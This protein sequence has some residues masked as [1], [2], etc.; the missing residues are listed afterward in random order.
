MLNKLCAL[1]CL[2]ASTG[3]VHAADAPPK[4]KQPF[5]QDQVTV[6]SRADLTI[7][8]SRSDSEIKQRELW[9]GKQANGQ[10]GDWQKHGLSF[11]RNDPIVWAPPE[12]HWRVHVRIED[13]SGL[14]TPVPTAETKGSQVIIDRTAPSV[15]ITS[16]S[17]GT[18][19]RS[20]SVFDITWKVSDPHL[21]STPVT[22]RW[23]RTG[24]KTFTTIA[25]HVPNSGSYRWSV[26]KEMTATGVIEIIAWDRANNVGS[27]QVESLVVDALPPRA[28]ILGPQITASQ[29]VTLSTNARDAGP[30]GI[31]KVQ[32]WHSADNGTTWNEGPNLTKE[33]W[34]KLNWKAPADGNYQ[35]KLVATDHSGNTNPIPSTA[36]DGQAQILIDTVKPT[37]TLNSPIGVRQA[38]DGQ[39]SLR[40]IYKPDDQ[41][42]VNFT[43]NEENIAA[44]GVSVA[45]QLEEDAPWQ[46]LGSNLD[47]NKAFSFPIPNANTNSA[48]I[49]VQALDKAGNL[50]EI[51]AAETF[52]IR[53][54]IDG[55]ETVIEFD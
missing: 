27:T 47:T 23:S 40:R 30:S 55:G 17:A 5:G 48:R 21:H 12:G 45:I 26:P 54:T 7:G 24:D 14:A 46:S 22:I 32:L 41:V 8:N 28:N 35:L 38:G 34:D 19:L 25:E 16:P 11:G 52:R 31:A 36:N 6:T 3:L 33:P 4:E 20:G 37:I 51:I 29:N 39:G 43:V 42:T 13:I 10:W 9:Y 50:G 53:N 15:A 1:S 44:G 2:I 49:R 18:F